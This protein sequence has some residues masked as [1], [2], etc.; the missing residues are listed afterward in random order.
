[1]PSVWRLSN[2]MPGG[3]ACRLWRSC[4]DTG[5]AAGYGLMPLVLL[6]SVVMSP[7]AWATGP[8]DRT[9]Y[10]SVLPGDADYGYW[11][12]QAKSLDRVSYVLDPAGQRGTVQRVEVRPGDANVAGPYG[13]RA[14]VINTGNL[15]GFVDGQTVVMALGVLI[16]SKFASPPGNWNHFA[17]I[18]AAGGGNQSPLQLS[19]GSDQA[20]LSMRIVGGGQWVESG[21]PSG[22][23][24]EAFALGPL[25]KNRWHD[26]VVE[27]RFGCTGNGY[28][29]LWLDGSPLVDARD[30][31]IG[32]CGDPGLYWKQGF[33]R[34]AYEKVTCL[35]FSDTF[36]WASAVDALANYR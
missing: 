21:Q 34:S 32:Y 13:E 17:Q 4:I 19:L 8:I 16:D 27:I 25:T 18:H 11:S 9:N 30:R 33:Y 1:M 10:G 26:F 14:E 2:P 29:K 36:R 24:E 22:A 15:G 6:I 7:S 20:L 31:A 35:W 28:A 3:L 5:L 23:G 12:L